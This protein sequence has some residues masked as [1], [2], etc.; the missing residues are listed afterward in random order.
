MRGRKGKLGSMKFSQLFFPNPTNSAN[1]PFFSSPSLSR[2]PVITSSLTFSER[3]A[4]T[5]HRQLKLFNST[6]YISLRRLLFPLSL[7]S[8]SSLSDVV[9]LSTIFFA[10]S[11]FS[12]VL[13]FACSPFVAL[14]RR[15]WGN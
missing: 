13:S 2:L 5:L 6:I 8:S 12:H 14:Q 7:S 11:A 10:S 1:W 15:R 9:S 3:D 4:T